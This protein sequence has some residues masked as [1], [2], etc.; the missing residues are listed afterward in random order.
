MASNPLPSSPPKTDPPP[1][2]FSDYSVVLSVP[3]Q[4]AFT[5]LWTSEGHERVCRL[6]KLCS[7]FELFQRDELA[8]PLATFPEGKKLRD[9]GVRTTSTP[10]TVETQ[11]E[12]PSGKGSVITRQHFMMEETIPLLFGT[13]AKK[14]RLTGTLSW[15]ESAFSAFSA[16]S[17]SPSSCTLE[18]LYETVSNGG[19]VVWKLRTFSQEGDDPNKTRV[20]ERIEGWAP[21][22]LKWIVQNEATKAHRAHMDLYRSHLRSQKRPGQDHVQKGQRSPSAMNA[23]ILNAL[24]AFS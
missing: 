7:G 17:P 12:V 22:L 13:F 10:A 19:I 21:T 1:N 11:A 24:N 9:M 5:T 8:L 2:F 23:L 15:D 20:T 14:V 18:A 4:E 6:S 3:L 16:A